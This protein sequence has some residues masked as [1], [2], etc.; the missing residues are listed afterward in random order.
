M[1][2][3]VTDLSTQLHDVEHARANVTRAMK[4]F[5]ASKLPEKK[6]VGMLYQAR[7]I[8]RSR[9]N[10]RKVSEQEQSLKNRMPYFFAV[11]Q[12]LLAQQESGQMEGQAQNAPA[13]R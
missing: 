11:V 7:D 4:M 3:V 5:R 1:Q 12:D 13:Q 8:T 2:A 9:G 10:I 6:F